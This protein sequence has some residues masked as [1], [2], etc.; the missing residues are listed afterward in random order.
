MTI[1]TGL[2]GRDVRVTR[3][4]DIGMTILTVQAKFANVETMT[5]LYRLNWSVSNVCVLWGKEVPNKQD[6]KNATAKG[7]QKR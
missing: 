3:V 5:V 6:G 4:L 2:R 7:K 1:H